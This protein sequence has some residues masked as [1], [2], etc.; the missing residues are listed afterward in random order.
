MHSMVK[1]NAEGTGNGRGMGRTDS[2]YHVHIGVYW[3][4]HVNIVVEWVYHVNKGY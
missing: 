3:V 2:V 1:A 4:Y